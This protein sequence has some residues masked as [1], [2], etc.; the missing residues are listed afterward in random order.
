MNKGIGVATELDAM[1]EL[2][3]DIQGMAEANKPWNSQ[4]KAMYQ[5]QLDLLYKRATAI[6]SSAPI[7]HDCTY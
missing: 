5:T 3:V 7:D 1:N 2:H 6:Y 4:N